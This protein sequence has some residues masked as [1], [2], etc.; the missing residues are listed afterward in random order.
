M[1][2]E[3][4]YRNNMEFL[5]NSWPQVYNGVLQADIKDYELNITKSG[6]YNIAVRGN[7][8]YP[9]KVDLSVQAQVNAFL[10]NP[11]ALFKKP[12]WNKVDEGKE[13]YHDKLVKEIEN[14]S[15]YLKEHKSFDSYHKHLDGFFPFLLMMGIGA[16]YHIEKLIRQSNGIKEIIIVDESYE[17]LKISFHLIDWRPI[18][19]YFK[20]KNHGLYFV[21]TK[22]PD[23]AANLTLNTI[24]KYFSYQFYFI[25]FI[26]HYNSTFFET[27]K[28]NF[29]AKIE[30]GFSGQGF[31]DDE[32]IGLDHT[33]KNLNDGLPVY[34][35]ENKLPKKS[36]AF[37]IASGPSVDEDIKYIKE[38]QDKVIIISCGTALRVLFKNDIKPDFHMEIERPPHMTSIIENYGTKEYLKSIDMIGLNVINHKV[39]DMFKSAKIYFRENDAGSSIIPEDI[40]KLNHCNPT[41]VNGALSFLSDIGFQNIFMFGTDMGFKNVDT[42]H[43]KDSIYYNDEKLKVN[44]INLL[45]D[46]FPGNFNRE[47]KFLTTQIFNWCKQRAVNCIMDYKLQKKFNIN[48][49]NCSDGLYIDGTTPFR[50]KDIKINKKLKKEE[51]L[52]GIEKS[53]DNDF[54]KLHKEINNIYQKEK[55]ILLE[56]IKEIEELITKKEIETFKELFILIASTFEIANNPDHNSKSYLT[57]SLLKGTMYHYYTALYT[58]ALATS[59]KNKAINFINSSLPKLLEFLREV[60]NR[61]NCINL[62]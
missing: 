39:Y 51:V 29:L 36:T 44:S 24:Y 34:R 46:K 7:N 26:T 19:M 20:Q 30:L 1:D 23:D 4:N 49:F 8:I 48:Y 16:G 41:I 10:D 17:M 5:K 35:Y 3:K 2:L 21:I 54:E 38:H 6:E 18:F 59:D 56:N 25:P 31:Y 15:V 33:I 61:V 43:S 14:S 22:T 12:T 28:E 40:P 32:I 53:F 50:A 52:S 58:H 55:E 13:Y 45:K 47:E 60:E 9:A 11:P 57:R 37:L 27:F 62:D 42:H